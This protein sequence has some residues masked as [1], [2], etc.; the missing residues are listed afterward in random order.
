MI[1]SFRGEHLSAFKLVTNSLL[2]LTSHFEQKLR[3]LKTFTIFFLIFCDTSVL[4]LCSCYTSWGAR[5]TALAS[6][7]CGPGSNPGA[8]AICVLNLLFVVGS[9][10]YSETVF[11]FPRVLRF[12]ALLKNQRFQIP[13]RSGTHRHILKSSHQLLSAPWV[14]KLQF[15]F[16]FTN[17]FLLRFSYA[18]LFNSVL[19]YLYDCI[20]DPALALTCNTIIRL[21]SILYTRYFC[22]RCLQT[23]PKPRAK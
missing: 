21:G 13:I 14:N 7:Q 15:T 12:S 5:V 20:Y 22:T 19:F 11:F 3:Y 1:R 8:D 6:N 18:Q 16:S 9:L 4:K 10:P 2:V 23:Y 17:Y